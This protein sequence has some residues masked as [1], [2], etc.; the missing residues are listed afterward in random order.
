M[1]KHLPA[2]RKF[3][4]EAEELLGSINDPGQ[5][6]TVYALLAIAHG[7]MEAGFD[8]NEVKSAIETK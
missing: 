7:V 6:A 5:K 1:S 2:A 3:A 4:N 8:L